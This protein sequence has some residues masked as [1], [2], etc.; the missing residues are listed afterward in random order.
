[1]PFDHVRHWLLSAREV[2]GA[3]VVSP[4]FYLQLGL[5]V[6]CALVAWASRALF[7]ARFD[8]SSMAMGWPGRL[9]QFMRVLVGS[10]PIAVFAALVSL[11]GI[12]I[13]ETAL[14][15][16]A[17]LLLAAAQLALA[18]LAIRLV[19]SAIRDPLLVSLVSV[20]AWCVAVLG[21]VGQLQAVSAALDSVAIVLG[22]LRLSPLLVIKLV[23]LL[24]LALWASKLLSQFLESRI[25]RSSDLTPSM[26][27]L[28]IKLTHVVLMVLAVVLVLGAVGINLSA[29]AIFSGAVGV[30]V[31]L[32]LQKIV[33]NFISGVILLVD[34]SVKPGDLVSVGDSTGRISAMNTR[35]ISI[36]AGDGRAILI[37][38]ED[39]VTQKVVNWTYSDTNALVKVKF[40]A[41]Y[42]ADPRHVCQLAVSVATATTQVSDSKP[43]VCLLTEFG[44]NGLLFALS[45]WIADPSGMD[46]TRS[47]VMAALWEAFRR[48]NIRMPYPVRDIRMAQPPLAA[49]TPAGGS[50]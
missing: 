42:D 11:L 27:V 22:D 29:L 23:V 50:R 5:I 15:G 3:A 28:L 35:Y 17:W 14:G 10:A 1:M 19:T 20:L 34:K 7:R 39:L 12:L 24:A 48:E 8:V 18:W 32:G 2:I 4:E 13:R 41:T 21:I 46:A 30:G 49:E 40:G 26:Q 33:S 36:A 43:P 37:P 44:D 25:T 38:N 6:V 9:R 16:T 31:G 45:F 47:E